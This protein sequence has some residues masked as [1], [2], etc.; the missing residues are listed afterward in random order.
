MRSFAFTLGAA[1]LGCAAIWQATDGLRAFT[2]EGA[3]RIAVA[4]DPR[5][6]PAVAVETMDGQTITL[7]QQGTALVEFIY[8]SCPTICQTSGGDFAELRDHLAAA[9]LTLPMYSLSFDPEVDERAAMRDYARAHTATGSPWTIARPKPEELQD[10]LD[11]FAV[12]VIPDGW[13]GYTHNI[14]V[15]MINADGAFSGAFDTRAFDAIQT[16]LED[17]Q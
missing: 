14:A 1:F 3:R 10:L 5:P 4:R 12:T 11:T 16:A 7:A 15:L 8:T 13:G 2:A 9:G 17:A 6:L